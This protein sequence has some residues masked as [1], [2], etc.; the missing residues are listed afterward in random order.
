MRLHALW[1]SLLGL[2]TLA[3][4]AGW[5]RQA[6]LNP[7]PWKPRQQAQVW[8]EGRALRW[9][10]VAVETDSISGVSFVQAADCDSCR[11]KIALEHVDS[12]RIGNPMAGFWKTFG[13]VVG[14]PLLLIHIVCGWPVSRTCFPAT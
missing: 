10:G 11:V 4:S 3:C 12:V 14:V 13:L 9:H 7:G 6:E 5:R 8:T 1:C 2:G